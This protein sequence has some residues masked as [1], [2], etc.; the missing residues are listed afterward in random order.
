MTDSDPNKKKSAPHQEPRNTSRRDLLKGAGL[1]GAVVAGGTHGVLAQDASTEAETIPVREALEVL[2]REETLILESICDTL[3]PGDELGPGAQEARAAHYID[4]SLASHNKEDRDDY[5]HS[6]QAI[7]DH[8]Q[9]LHGSDFF[10]LDDNSRQQILQALQDDEVPNCSPGSAAFFNKVRSHTIDGTFC[11]PYYGGNRD[12]VGWDL[13]RYPGI[14][15]GASEEDVAQG[16]SLPASHQ[17]AYDHAAYTKSAATSRPGDSD[18][19]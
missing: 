17:S 7:N 5:L 19:D 14:R 4:K 13:L 6:L 12:F 8:A 16:S 15:L 2:T 11:D 18:N 1:L 9:R 3:I 10:Q